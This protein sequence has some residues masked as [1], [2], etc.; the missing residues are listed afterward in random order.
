[1]QVKRAIAM[2]FLGSAILAV[3]IVGSGFMAANTSTDNGIRLFINAL[4][5]ALGLA[6]VIR[7]GLKVSGSHFNPAVSLVMLILKKITPKLFALYLMVQTIGAIFG[8]LLAN[9]IFDQKLIVQSQIYRDGSNLLISETFATLVLLWIILRFPKRDDLIAIYAPLWIFGA[10]IFTSSTSF[11]NPA[12]TIGRIFTS[13]IVGI[14]PSS[15]FA[16]ILAQLIGAVMGL[17][18]SKQVTNPGKDSDE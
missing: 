4:A 17:L 6:V 18:I 8:T 7:I 16:F 13:S 5:T 9:L 10:I 12:I 15:A 3:A 1:M 11:A 14:S 2:E